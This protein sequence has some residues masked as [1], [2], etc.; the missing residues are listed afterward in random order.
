MLSE[1]SQKKISSNSVVL[2]RFQ[3]DIF[4]KKEFSNCKREH[5]GKER[6]KRKHKNRINKTKKQRKGKRKKKEKKEE[7]RKKKR[8]KVHKIK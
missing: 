6:R 2:I 4:L 5:N 7:R 3:F 1:N 8:R